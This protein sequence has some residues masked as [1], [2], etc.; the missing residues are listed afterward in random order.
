MFVI[1]IQNF[2]DQ[3]PVNDW[4]IK[5]MAFTADIKCTSLGGTCKNTK[6]GCSGGNFRSGLCSGPTTR[7]CCVRSTGNSYIYDII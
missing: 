7:K 1:I 5:I 6:A 3:L 4:I 2:Y